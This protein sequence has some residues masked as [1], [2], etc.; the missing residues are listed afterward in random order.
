MAVERLLANALGQ[1]PQVMQAETG[2]QMDRERLELDRMLANA[3]LNESERRFALDE[4]LAKAGMGESERRL[5]LDEMLTGAGMANQQWQRGMAEKEFGLA[6]QELKLKADQLAKQYGSGASDGIDW[7]SEYYGFI[8][9]IA[10]GSV[11]GE[12]A[13]SIVDGL[14][15]LGV[16]TPEQAEKM[17]RGLRAYLGLPEP[18][19][20]QTGT[21]GA[22]NPQTEAAG[23]TGRYF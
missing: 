22:A 21:A 11:S 20:A 23:G 13:L 6:E 14:I 17:K 4:M 10:G 8:E 5:A 18:G 1:A 9:A 12:Q 3:G 19:A 2:Y 7:G 16:Y 15:A